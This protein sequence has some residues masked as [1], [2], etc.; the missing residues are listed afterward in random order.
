LVRPLAA[1]EIIR[2]IPIAGGIVEAEFHAG[3]VAGGGKPLDDVLAVGRGH[4]VIF[5]EFGIE[6]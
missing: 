1:D 5:R 3:L 4:D 6:H 2:V